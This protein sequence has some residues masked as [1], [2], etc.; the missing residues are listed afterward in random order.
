MVEGYRFR[1]QYQGTQRKINSI[2]EVKGYIDT[3]ALIFVAM[4]QP[5]ETIWRTL[6]EK[7]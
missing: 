5:A 4:G 7:V 6:N 2:N 3:K 1:S